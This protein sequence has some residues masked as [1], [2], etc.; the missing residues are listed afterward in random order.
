MVIVHDNTELRLEIREQQNRQLFFIYHVRHINCDTSK[1]NGIEKVPLIKLTKSLQVFSYIGHTLSSF[2]LAA[3]YKSFKSSQVSIK[4]LGKYPY[5]TNKEHIWTA[6]PLALI[7]RKI[8][9][10][11]LTYQEVI[12]ILIQQHVLVD[13]KIRIGKTYPAGFMHVIS[14]PKTNENFCLLYDT[15][16]R[17]KIQAIKD[18]EAKFKLYKVRSVHFG[19]TRR[20]R[21]PDP[22]LRANDAIKI[23]LETNK[24][25]DF[26]KE[27]HKSTFDTIHLQDATSHEYFTLQPMFLPLAMV[28][29]HGSLFPRAR[30]SRSLLLKKLKRAAAQDART[31]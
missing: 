23:D 25:I 2:L 29:S 30:V 28:Q 10:Y 31:A 13:V 8:L 22:L 18:E 15:K 24:I 9:K 17:F 27:N 20:I 4:Y 1:R 12:A 26:I 14:I 21:Y 3:P 7:L 19:Q 5:A 6:L 11:A 16:G